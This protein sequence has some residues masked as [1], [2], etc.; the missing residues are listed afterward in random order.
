MAVNGVKLGTSVKAFNIGVAAASNCVMGPM[1][2][3]CSMVRSTDR[4]FHGRTVAVA[5]AF[6]YSDLGG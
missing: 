2:T 5:P 1:P 4:A 6:A 3:I